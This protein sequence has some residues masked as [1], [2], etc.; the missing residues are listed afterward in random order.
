MITL[1]QYINDTLPVSAEYI[2]HG[3]PFRLVGQS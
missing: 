1:T 2:P 3:A